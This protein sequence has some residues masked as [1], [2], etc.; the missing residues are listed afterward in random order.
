MQAMIF[1]GASRSVS[2]VME[3]GVGSLLASVVLTSWSI[4]VLRRVRRHDFA[5]NLVG[6]PLFELR[7][8]EKG[9][10]ALS[11]ESSAWSERW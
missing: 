2:G 11:E 5:D 4:V 7:S 1:L 9:I 6:C 3:L 8:I 10:N